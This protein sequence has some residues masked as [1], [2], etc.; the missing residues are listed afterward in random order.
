MALTLKDAKQ[1][2]QQ[3]ANTYA[4]HFYGQGASSQAESDTFTEG[5]RVII[6]APDGRQVEDWNFAS[7]ESAM[8]RLYNEVHGE[9]QLKLLRGSLNFLLVFD[10]CKAIW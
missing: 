1:Q 10:E 3:V 7:W 2:L 8:D 6:L 9:Q 5:W 4:V